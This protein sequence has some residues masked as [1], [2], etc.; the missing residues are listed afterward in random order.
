[1]LKIVKE[2]S[3]HRLT[4]EIGIDLFQNDKSYSAVQT[5]GVSVMPL[6]D[7][8]HIV[9]SGKLIIRSPVKPIPRH[10]S[11]VSTNTCFDF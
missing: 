9:F 4:I 10:I 6:V 1:M 11:C 2:Q 3:E 7:F 8:F 5:L